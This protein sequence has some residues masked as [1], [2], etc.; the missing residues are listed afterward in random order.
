[1]RAKALAVAEA[2]VRHA[3]SGAP[4]SG[5]PRLPVEYKDFFVDNLAEV[6][7]L[8]AAEGKVGVCL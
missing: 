6:E 7:A 5:G 8:V 3:G 2:L 4:A 1:M